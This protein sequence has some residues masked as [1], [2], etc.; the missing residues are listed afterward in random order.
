M[1]LDYVF[2]AILDGHGA[3]SCFDLEAFDTQKKIRLAAYHYSPC[4]IGMVCQVVNPSG[5]SAYVVTCFSGTYDCTLYVFCA[6]CLSS[7]IDYRLPSFF[8]CMDYELVIF[9]LVWMMRF[10]P[11]QL[12]VL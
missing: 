3:L 11:F 8:H 1:H 2:E 12:C 4:I 5:L 10:L 6:S 7:E 9:L